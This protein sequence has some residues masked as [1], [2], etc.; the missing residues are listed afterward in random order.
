MCIISCHRYLMFIQMAPSKHVSFE[1]PFYPP[2]FVWPKFCAHFY[3]FP[4]SH[5]PQPGL[6]P[7]IGGPLSEYPCSINRHVSNT[8]LPELL[9]PMAPQPLVGQGL[10]IEASRSHSDTHT[11]YDSPGLVISPT[12][13]LYPTDSTQH[14]QQI[15]IYAQAG[16]EPTVSAGER[17]QAHT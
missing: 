10:I 16:F 15:D 2:R 1:W 3:L 4:V 6:I 12:Q 9:F 17:P 13:N 7:D 8:V 14:S 5:H 11:L